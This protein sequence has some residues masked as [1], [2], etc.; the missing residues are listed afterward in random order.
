MARSKLVPNEIETETVVIE[1][2]PKKKTFAE[3]DYILCR[4]V[5]PG[6]LNINCRSR[7]YYEFKDYG[8][9]C[10]IEYRDLAELVRKHSDHVFLPRFIIMDD[11][12][13]KEF[14]QLKKVYENLFTISD[15]KEILLLPAGQMQ[16]AINQLPEGIKGGLKNLAAEM[17]N[18]GEIDSVKSI[19]TLSD[20]FGSDFNLL[21]EL[22]TK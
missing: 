21:S 19:R 11:D 1:E 9:E 3:N 17:I 16:K 14:P 22:F 20:I 2:K 15:L 5:I 7:N 10:E 8:S 12:F 6:G 13:I 4:S 18:S